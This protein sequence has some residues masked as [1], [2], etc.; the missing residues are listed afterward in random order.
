MAPHQKKLYI[1]GINLKKKLRTLS[2]VFDLTDLCTQYQIW[3]DQIVIAAKGSNLVSKIANVDTAT[4][5]LG[6]GGAGIQLESARSQKV[7]GVLIED[8][9]KIL[10]TLE[11]HNLPIGSPEFHL[12]TNSLYFEDK[13]VKITERSDTNATKLLGLLFSDPYKKWFRDEIFE[14]LGEEFN[15]KKSANRYYNAARDVNNLIE[16]K[17]GCNDLLTYTE[18]EFEINSKY[19]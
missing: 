12:E 8:I 11:N 10:D 15:K 18:T 1:E 9:E 5:E 13:I 4:W 6:N 14:E 17:T 2:H 7:I 3:R 19:L 16:Q